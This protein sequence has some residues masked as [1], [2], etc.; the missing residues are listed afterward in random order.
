MSRVNPKTFFLLVLFTLGL[1]VAG[2]LAA[3]DDKAKPTGRLTIDHYFKLGSVSDPQLNPAGTFIA[4]TVSRKDLEEDESKSRIWMVKAGGGEPVA[5]TAK[6]QSSSHARWSPD[7][8]YLAFLSA[9]DDGETQVWMLYLGGGEA[10]QVTETVQSVSAFQWSPDSSRI[11][12]LLQDP[13]PQQLAVEEEGDSYE[14]KA[15][16][17]WVI[18][19]MQFKTDYVGYLDRRRTHI[20][21][22]DVATREV[23]QLTSGDYD[24]SEAAWSPDGKFIA[25]TSNRTAD[26][27]NNRNSDIWII[28]ADKAGNALRVTGN[29]GS[30]ASPAWSPDGKNIVHTAI[31]DT[32]ASLYAT[33]H[34][35]VSSA[36]GRQTELLTG[37]L[38]RMIFSP[39]YSPDGEHIWFLLEDHG[40][41][42]LARLQARGKD[43]QPERI[44]QGENT[45]SDFSMKAEGTAVLLSKPLL[46]S[47]IF[48][49]SD[50]QLE[51]RTFTNREVLEG[52]ELGQVEQ[53]SFNSKDGTPIQG[54]VIKPPGFKQGKR[55][56]VILD[57]HGGPQSQYDYGFNFDGQLY[58]ANGYLVVHPNPR[59][60]TGYG[61]E[62]CLAIWRNW[63]GPD[64]ED[65]MASVDDVI[66]RGWGDPDRMAVTGWSYGGM[67]TNHVITRTDRF[68]A[69]VTGASATLYVANYGHDMYQRWW[70]EELG[71][72][73]EPEARERYEEISPFNKLDQVVTPTLILGGE[74][75][76]NVPILNS[77]QLYIALKKL[78]VEAQLIVYP[79]QYHGIGKPSYIKD[80][81]ERYLDWFD[82]H[83]EDAN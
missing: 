7:G 43:R 77:E 32:D 35:A 4:Y 10:V 45:V 2:H 12:L 56:P 74:K 57:I 41:Q 78:G 33:Q 8:R 29:P 58:A 13:T 40:E 65:V 31:T 28:A 46:P 81:S 19:R 17:P 48:M 22:M 15:A 69:A 42:N 24:D 60:S 49:L 82:R 6:E 5:M 54:F 38:D 72:P 36:G 26:P 61:Q 67:L 75:D 11:L 27:D 59:G 21:V 68:K 80:L 37:D 25:F 62:F 51:Q 30:D 9:R 50:E 14:E 18:D 55:Y 79:G 1:T 23:T 16:P 64:Y 20:Y 63:G 47:E 44:I 73:W 76:W 71:R 39:R 83:L 70:D 3:N 34:L 52:L 66:E 53:L